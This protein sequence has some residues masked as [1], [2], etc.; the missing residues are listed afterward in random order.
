VQYPVAQMNTGIIANGS[1]MLRTQEILIHWAEQG[2]K[3]CP[4]ITGR[5]DCL[6]VTGEHWGM[7]QGIF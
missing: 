3:G 7:K 1:F 6:P 5:A 4:A 2:H